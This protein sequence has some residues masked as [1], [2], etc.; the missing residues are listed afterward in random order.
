MRDQEVSGYKVDLDTPL[1]KFLSG[2]ALFVFFIG[3]FVLKEGYLGGKHSP[4]SPGLVPYGF[5]L[6]VATIVIGLCRFLT[7][8]YYVVV[9]DEQTIYYRFKF[10][11]YEQVEL[12]KRSTDLEMVAVQ[13]RLKHS[14]HS[15]WY[16]Y[17]VVLI[18]N[19][20]EQIP[21]SDELRHDEGLYQA[22]E[23]A[24]TIGKSLG[25]PVVCGQSEHRL[26]VGKERGVIEVTQK[27]APD[28]FGLEPSENNPEIPTILGFIFIFIAI[29]VF[30]LLFS[31]M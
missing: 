5:G 28:G 3:L 13:G 25:L 16:Q 6:M 7:D 22:N 4:P 24:E 1:E 30:I 19:R 31:S 17:G 27:A 14:K 10:I 8:C 9:D 11:F 18:D 26:L 29:G 21:F 12:F 20:G 15:R 2:G 23:L